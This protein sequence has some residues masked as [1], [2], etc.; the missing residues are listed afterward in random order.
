MTLYVL[1][2][3]EFKICQLSLGL[4]RI[5]SGGVLTPSRPLTPPYYCSCVF[6]LQSVEDI[7]RPIIFYFLKE[8]IYF[9]FL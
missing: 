3:D 2:I 7:A 8:S 4:Q 5:Q 9:F 1:P 6:L